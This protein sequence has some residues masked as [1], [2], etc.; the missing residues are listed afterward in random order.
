MNAAP[1][2]FRADPDAINASA[3]RSLIRA[4]IATGARVFEK[5]RSGKMP[6]T[7][8]VLARKN[9]GDDRLAMLLVRA[10]SAPAMTTQAG[11]AQELAPL[12][13]ALLEALIPMSAAAQVL[14]AGL[15]VGFGGAGSIRIPALG[16]A[17]AG[18]VQEGQPIR[19]VRFLSTGPTMTPR[20][21]ASVA[22]T[23]EM[24]ANHNCEQFVRTALINSVAPALDAALFSNAAASSAQPAGVLVGAVNVTASSSADL[25]D[26]MATDIGGLAS[27]VGAYAGNGS[28]IF[29][30][31]AAQ[32][33]RYLMY[34]DTPWPMAMSAAVPAGMIICI[35]TSALAS[36]IEPPV[37]DV[38]GIDRVA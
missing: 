4:A 5:D 8:T 7:E 13:I 14:A 24:L 35:A 33:A 18:W 10:A 23:L 29:V 36:A 26:D 1:I 6:T 30:G 17:P 3:M 27:A 31:N 22:L 34:S 25:F 19:A 2:P 38:V 37:I 11:W 16:G 21:L 15:G 12:S 20:K 32:V 28:L 9:W